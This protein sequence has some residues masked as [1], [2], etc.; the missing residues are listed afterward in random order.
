M[1]L[2][3][4]LARALKKYM[5][6]KAE[7]G[8][9]ALLIGVGGAESASDDKARDNG[10]G[11]TNGHKSKDK[12]GPAEERGDV[13]GIP[14]PSRFEARGMQWQQTQFKVLC[15]ECQG[16]LRFSE[17]CETCESCGYSKC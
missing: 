13:G 15:P 17:G 5:N 7:R 12:S 3:D 2:G 10:N 6:A 16:S 11:R 9:R 14:V 4:G 8:L 1:S